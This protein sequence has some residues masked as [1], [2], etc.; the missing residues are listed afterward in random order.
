MLVDNG[1]NIAYEARSANGGTEGTLTLA[2]VQQPIFSA[3]DVANTARAQI[4][5]PLKSQMRA[6]VSV[7]G[8]NGAILVLA[9]TRDGP[10]FGTDVSLQKART[11]TFFSRTDA[12]VLLGVAQTRQNSDGG[13][14][15]Q[16]AADTFT[17][18]L[19]AIRGTD[20]A[21]S[22]VGGTSLA[23]GTAFADRSGGNL[24]RPFFPGG[25]S[26][27]LPGPLIHPIRS[28]SPFAT[29]LQ[30]DLV[31]EELTELLLGAN[32][33]TKNIGASI[34]DACATFNNISDNT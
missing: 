16:V 19:S 3:L 15:P 14:V 34:D 30:L 33:G 2:E 22:G 20:A 13:G 5:R 31:F 32:A 28:W 10:L 29:G 8:L 4:R 9:R 25:I 24:A 27:Q 12:D 11:A 26:G 18:R 17:R 7:V 23:D 21:F 1:E 6:T